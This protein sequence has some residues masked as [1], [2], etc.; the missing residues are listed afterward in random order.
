MLTRTDTRRRSVGLFFLLL[1]VVMVTWGQTVLKPHLEQLSFVIYWL[2]CIFCLMVAVF[3]ALLDMWVMGR[4]NR[5][6]QEE[7]Y[8]RTMMEIKL[9]QDAARQ[10]E[11]LGE[12]SQPG[13][14]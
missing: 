8:Q 14:S 2:V 11:K 3:L 1:A 4:R 12:K 10:E 5:R 7:L 9:K 6:Q 13:A